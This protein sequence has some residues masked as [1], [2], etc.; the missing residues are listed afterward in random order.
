MG[1]TWKS[2]GHVFASGFHDLVVAARAVALFSA[3]VQP[4]ASTIESITSLVP[5]YGPEA[6]TIERLA[7][8]ALGEFAAIVNAAGGAS[9]AA[10]LV[11]VDPVLLQE[12]EAALKNNPQLVKQAAALVGI[13]NA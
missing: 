12:V 8:A 5:I 1:I 2:V 13:K 6:A 11:P 3:K 7:F 10:S 9:A 4:E